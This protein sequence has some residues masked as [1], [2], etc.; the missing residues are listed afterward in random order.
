MKI[1]PKVSINLCVY[2]GENYLREA[3]ESIVAQTYK[4]WELVIINDGSTDSTES[5][6][7]EYI[8][9]G[10]PIIYHYQKNHGLGYS[11]NEA[12]KRSQGEFI[13]FI[14][15][16]DLWL[17]EKLSKQVLTFENNPEVG[18]LYSNFFMMDQEKGKKYL[19]YRKLQPSGFV[20]EHFLHRYSVGILTVLI[21][22]KVFDKLNEFFDC[23]LKLTEEYDVFMRILFYA[24]ALYMPEPLADYRIHSNMS[25]LRCM[26]NYPDE[27]EY[28]AEKLKMLD[29]NGP[30]KY[31]KAFKEHKVQLEYFK[32]KIKMAQG[33]L[34]KARSHLA[35]YK[36][37]NYKFFILYCASYL[38]SSLWLFM[39][40]LWEKDL[41]R[42]LL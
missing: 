22:K 29:K 15:H 42:R 12:F 33:D 14:D 41:F 3:L 23:K 20:F 37:S 4:D 34:K 13:A 21:R 5:I 16:D 10:Y 17:P 8:N 27:M 28:V 2:N 40:P 31:A 7:K 6:I 19:A 1:M 38:P 35:S 36:L 24:V 25:S 32:A 18:F 9:K 39:H 11:R 26:T 30:L